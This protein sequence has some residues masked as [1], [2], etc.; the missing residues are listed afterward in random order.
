MNPHPLPS[1]T[2]PTRGGELA[3]RGDGVPGCQR[4]TVPTATPPPPS[5]PSPLPVS[6]ALLSSPHRRPA[7][8]KR[9]SATSASQ[10][11]ESS[12]AFLSRPFRRL[13]NKILV[14]IRC[15]TTFPHP[16][17]CPSDRSH[18][19][20]PFLVRQSS[21]ERNPP[22][23]DRRISGSSRPF[24]LLL[25]AVASFCRSITSRRRSGGVG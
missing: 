7:W 3:A 24:L 12:Y 11:M 22:P 20:A 2:N 18:R 8:E 4:S 15:S 17:A 21:S 16:M 6:A 9:M 23:S 1:G 13:E 10:R 14:L 5:L 25:P 19:L